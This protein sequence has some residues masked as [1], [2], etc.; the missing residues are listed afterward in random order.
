M[1]P[2][3]KELILGRR[4]ALKMLGF[5]SAAM[6]AGG[7]TDISAAEA[8]AEMKPKQKPLLVSGN[9]SVAFTTGNDRQQMLYEVMKPFE[10]EIKAGLKGKQLIIKPNMVVT[11][12][13]LCATHPDALGALLEFLKPIYKGQVI[14]G[15]S[16]SSFNSSDG[17]KNYGY[18]DLEKKYNCKFV[19]L[20]GSEG[21]PFYIID[22]NLHL[23]KIQ[24]IEP[25][26]NP[27][28]YV[29]SISRLKTHNTV[30]MTGGTKN[31][32][33]GAPAFIPAAEGSRPTSFKRNMHAGGPRWCH[34]NIFLVT[35]QVR[36]DFTIIDGLEGMEGNGP[37]SGTPVNHKIALAG[38]DV[39]AVDSMCCKLM[40]IPLEDIGYLN[41]LAASGY[42]NIDYNKIDIIG[43]QNPEQHIIKYKLSSNAAYQLEWKEPLN[44]PTT[45]PT[46]QQRPPEGQ[47]QR[48]PIR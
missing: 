19:D 17:F 15:E 26:V 5:S 42:G 30:V 1:K 21:K 41:Y 46:Q 31:M 16:S 11:N 40:G 45:R 13:P 23:D 22:R 36:P 27:N 34:Y 29:I 24:L 39:V 2:K 33:M 8:A 44:L 28:N 7:F 9:S 25:L 10:K 38:E 3:E 12:V 47:Q 32:A 37:I 4:S 18:L 35:P 43:S 14:I 48:P 20:N 6:L